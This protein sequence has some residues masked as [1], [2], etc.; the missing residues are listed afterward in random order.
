MSV[1]QSLWSSVPGDP[2]SM[3]S[4]EF[5]TRLALSQHLMDVHEEDVLNSD[6]AE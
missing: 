6:P 1:P 4:Q 3:R 5:D 2:V